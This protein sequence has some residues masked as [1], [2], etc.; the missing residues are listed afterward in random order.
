M[1]DYKRGDDGENMW[2]ACINCGELIHI[3]TTDTPLCPCCG[4]WWFEPSI[5]E[6]LQGITNHILGELIDEQTTE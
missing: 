3:K 1:G 5:Y 2:V 4:D 6:V